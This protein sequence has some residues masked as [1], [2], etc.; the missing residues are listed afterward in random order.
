[1][2]RVL[3]AAR[4]LLEEI[5]LEPED[6]AVEIAQ[7][8]AA[9]METPKGSVPLERDM[10]MAMDYLDLPPRIA[11]RQLEAEVN[12]ALDNWEPR[13]EFRSVWSEETDD[14]SMSQVVEVSING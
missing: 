5:K 3:T 13:A 11:I 4:D 12:E 10:G 7:N 1:M 2:E 14:G 8:I 9:L 6:E